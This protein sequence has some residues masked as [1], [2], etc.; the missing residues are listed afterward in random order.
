M[1]RYAIVETGSKQYW[2]E[3]KS[4]IEVEKLDAGDKKQIVLD[5]V[6]FLRKENQIE[7]G[8]PTVKGAKVI[9]EWLGEV[10]GEK[11]IALKYR[12]RKASRTKKG[13]RQHLTKL[14]VKEISG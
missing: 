9:C 10:K 13:H 3:P 2:V 6:L 1:S 11:L 7:I 12:K 4:V 5:Q 14:C 8:S